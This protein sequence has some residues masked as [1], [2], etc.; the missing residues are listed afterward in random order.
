M[1]FAHRIMAELD[2]DHRD[3]WLTLYFERLL[4]RDHNAG[5][6]RLELCRF[7]ARYQY[8]GSRIGYPENPPFWISAASQAAMRELRDLEGD[9]VI[10][11]A[12]DEGL[13]ANAR[14]AAHHIRQ[15][16]WFSND[17]PTG[18]KL[19]WRFLNEHWAPQTNIDDALRVANTQRPHWF[20]ANPRKVYE[21]HTM[22][23]P[24]W[25]AWITLLGGDEE[26]LRAARPEIAGALHH[27]RW[28]A[29]Y[30]STFF[31]ATLLRTE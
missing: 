2:P 20:W 25:A 26:T 24:L 19:N 21:D 13:L 9:P 31:I 30:S 10:R 23:E 6:S 16:R 22:R 1:L 27:Y 28:R 18:Y 7:G 5:P 17:E 4:E 12:Y 29:L 14:A 11:E 3:E 15:Y 8:P